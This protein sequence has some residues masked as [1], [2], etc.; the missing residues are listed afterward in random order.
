MALNLNKHAN[1]ALPDKVVLSNQTYL[2]IVSEVSLFS[3][4]ETGGIF[5][6]TIAH[7]NWYI[8]ESIDPGYE[9][10]VRHHAYFE[11]DVKYVNHLAN[12]RKALYEKELVLMG[13]WH[14]HPGSMDTFSSP[15]MET[16]KGFVDKLPSGALSAIINID[17][18]FRI[19]MY[20]FTPA[21]R[22]TK[23]KK[24]YVGDEHIPRENIILILTRR[25]G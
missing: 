5:L 21:M 11:Y 7:N 15:D 12:V 18:Q 24:I 3:D 1:I 17:P 25:F 2:S 13:L 8:I 23:C 9:N 6:G 14:R 10:S 19:T 22:C 4:I 20:H 16:N